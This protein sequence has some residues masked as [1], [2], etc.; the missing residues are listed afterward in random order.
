MNGSGATELVRDAITGQPNLSAAL[1]GWTVDLSDAADLPMPT[2]SDAPA[3]AARITTPLAMLASPSAVPSPPRD[4]GAAAA[5]QDQPEDS[6]GTGRVEVDARD[7]VG[8]IQIRLVRSGTTDTRIVT[9]ASQASVALSEACRMLHDRLLD[10]DTKMRENVVVCAGDPERDGLVLP[11]DVTAFE[12]LALFGCG[13]LPP[14][15]YVKRAWLH[16]TGATELILLIRVGKPELLD[17]GAYKLD[18]L[19]H[20]LW[21]LR[22]AGPGLWLDQATSRAK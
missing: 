12:L 11:L 16:L 9:Y 22:F 7:S 1:A 8:G 20:T 14:V 5:G 17:C 6:Q 13:Q 2:K 15:S 10:K 4:D 19:P 21:L 3:T 18:D